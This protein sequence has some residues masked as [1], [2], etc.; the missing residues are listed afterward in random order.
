MIYFNNQFVTNEQFVVHADNRAFKYGD[1]VFESLLVIHQE[2]PLLNYALARLKKGMALLGMEIPESWNADF[3]KPLIA[4]LCKYK[5]FDECRCKITVWRSGAGLYLPQTN[6]PALL[7]EVFAL[8]NPVL[9]PL[10]S[11]QLGLY[12]NYPKLM[13]PL[14]ACKT[15]NALPYVMAALYAQQHHYDDVLLLNTENTIADAISS[16]IFIV[17]NNVVYTTQPLNGGVEGT[18]QTYI[19][20]HATQLSLEITR[21]NMTV[22][23]VLGADEVFLTNAIQGIRPVSRFEDATYQNN[24]TIS[25]LHQLKRVLLGDYK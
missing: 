24:F 9:E 10:P 3:F 17:K 4:Q 22:N 11:I 13:H 19:I 15:S 2:A 6:T 14:S 21:I 16:N 12:E 1:A 8:S 7:I 23:E 20:D 18:M 25:L 5:D